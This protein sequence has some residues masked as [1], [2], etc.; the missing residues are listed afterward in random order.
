MP[1]APDPGRRG[2]GRRQLEPGPKSLRRWSCR[3]AQGGQGQ[4]RP[5]RGP[6]RPV[7]P[8]LA[9]VQGL[10]LNATFV[11]G[12]TQY[13]S[14]NGRLY[15]RGQHLDGPGD[16]A[17]PPGRRPGHSRRGDP[18]GR[19]AIAT[20]WPIPNGS[21]PPARSRPRPE[22]RPAAGGRPARRAARPAP[23]MPGPRPSSAS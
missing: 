23:K 13:A 2:L 20:P 10:T 12:T 15:E 17:L 3:P 1:P 18:R 22:V 7:D 11:Q 6:G 5:R 14:I 9:L 4:G 19:T 8:Y 21:R 16:E